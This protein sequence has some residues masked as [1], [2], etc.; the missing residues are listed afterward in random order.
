MAGGI[1]QRS[2]RIGLLLDKEGL[3]VND[4]HNQRTAMLH[5]AYERA[6]VLRRCAWDSHAG[7]ERDACFVHVALSVGLFSHSN[8]DGVHDD[9]P[10]ERLFDISCNLKLIFF[11]LF[12]FF[13]IRN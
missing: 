8:L 12:S 10:R 5:V 11:F 9:S 6:S 7:S 3:L 1:L 2:R 13:N 4:V